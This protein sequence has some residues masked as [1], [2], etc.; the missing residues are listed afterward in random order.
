M[1]IFVLS[2]IEWP[3]YTDFSVPQIMKL[4]KFDKNSN[5]LKLPKS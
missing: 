1:K 5:R 3:F 4:L 2:F